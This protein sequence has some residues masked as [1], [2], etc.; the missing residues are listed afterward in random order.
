MDRTKK[1]ERQWI[2]IDITYIAINLIKTRLGEIGIAIIATM[3][4]ANK[5]KRNEWKKSDAFYHLAL[6]GN[7]DW[8]QGRRTGLSR[9]SDK[10]HEFMDD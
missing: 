7:F 4:D 2:G 8:K 5:S 10:F 6:H 9:I 1:L 3:A